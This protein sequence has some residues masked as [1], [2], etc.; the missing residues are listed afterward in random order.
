A[1][2]LAA[3]VCDNCGASVT[4]R[5]CGNC[6]QRLEAPM[7]TLGHF[8]MVAFEDVTH[9]DS[10]LWS[11]LGALLTRPGFLTHEFLSGRRARYLP[12]VR[13]YLVLSVAFFLVASWSRPQVL[14]LSTGAGGVPR[15]AR[16]VPLEQ[17][18]DIPGDKAR[19]GESV[20]QRNAR[21]CGMISIGGPLNPALQKA[22]LRI[23]GDGARSFVAAMRHNLPRAMFLFLPL[24]AGLMMLFY[25]RPRHYYVEHLLL[26]VHNHAC[27]FL[28]LP[29]AWGV[30]A[31]L[32]WL[33]GWMD[34]AVFLYLVW[35]MYR[36][37][38]TV[39][40]Q[41]RAL[42]ATKLAALGFLYFVFAIVMFVLNFAF[43][44][45]TLD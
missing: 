33:S 28:V 13:L 7:H 25:W 17:A 5:Y 9:A 19:P 16:V 31:L 38:R 18:G 22:C 39:Y 27:V 24:L 32:P 26:L 35:Y 34:F 6:G 23:R 36:S 41:G 14:Q 29:L 43:S 3:A 1:G 2:A 44:A 37:M 45:L 30:S 15:A 10:R 4:G 12:P 40:G 42:T 21:E 8:L 11:T 20:A